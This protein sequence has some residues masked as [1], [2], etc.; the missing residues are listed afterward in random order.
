MYFPR[1]WVTYLSSI[2]VSESY[3]YFILLQIKIDKYPTF[4]L[5]SSNCRINYF[6]NVRWKLSQKTQKAD[7]GLQRY[8]YIQDGIV[9]LQTKDDFR[10]L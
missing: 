1:K 2:L 8:F 10:S 4:F 5:I 9:H 3:Y 7:V 6:L